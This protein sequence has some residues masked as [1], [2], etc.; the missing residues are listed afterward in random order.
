MTINKTSTPPPLPKSHDDNKETQMNQETTDQ[1]TDTTTADDD[2]NLHELVEELKKKYESVFNADSELKTM[3]S[4]PMPME[5]VDNV[6]IKPLHMNVPRCTPYA[7]QKIAKAELDRLVELGILEKVS[8]SR[9]WIS[10][11]SF[12]PNPDGTVRLTADFV[13]L[14]KYV[15]RRVHPFTVRKTS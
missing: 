14:N 10:P 3:T 4:K 8:G 5:V 9:D 2:I 1:E 13:N 12:V 6:T 11:M 7:Y 15:K